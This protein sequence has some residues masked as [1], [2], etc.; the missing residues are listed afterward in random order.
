[1]EV[2]QIDYLTSVY[3]RIL[4]GLLGIWVI[5]SIAT[6]VCMGKRF[7]DKDESVRFWIPMIPGSLSS[8]ALLVLPSVDV[9]RRFLEV[10]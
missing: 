7:V 3:G 9:M 5:S 4:G 6:L 1:M 10:L 8:F 2:L